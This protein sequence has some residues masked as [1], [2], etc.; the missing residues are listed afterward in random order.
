M[1]LRQLLHRGA[2]C[3]SLNDCEQQHDRDDGGL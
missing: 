3:P 1:F 2:A